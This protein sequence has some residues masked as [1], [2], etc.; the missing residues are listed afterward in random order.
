V[1]KT[2]DIILAATEPRAPRPRGFV[3]WTPHGRTQRILDQVHDILHE[4]AAYLPLTIRQIFYRLVG[5]YAF[6]KTRQDYERLGDYL[7][8]AR[9]A[10]IIDM[11]DIRDDTSVIESPYSYPDG[12]AFLTAV[13]SDAEQLVLERSEGQTRKIILYAEAGGM[14]PQLTRVAHPYGISVHASGGYDSL[15]DKYK[16]A[17]IIADEDCPVDVLHIG[18]HDLDGVDLYRALMEDVQSFTDDEGGEVTFSRLA[19][20]PEQIARYNLPT[21]PRDEKY[22]GNKSERAERMG[23]MC[24]A[25]ALA[26]DVLERKQLSSAL[27]MTRMRLCSSLSGESRSAWCGC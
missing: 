14:V 27:I 26:P 7:N 15:T 4:Y 22:T 20:I 1:I 5:K 8:R 24:E 9:R 13:R 17:R 6:P 19:V 18:D 21:P 10:R 11:D 2:F 16:L 3:D 25:E 23:A 12:K